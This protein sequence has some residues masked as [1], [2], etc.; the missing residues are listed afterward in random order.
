MGFQDTRAARATLYHRADNLFRNKTEVS[1]VI[2]AQA[3]LL[4]SNWTP[5]TAL[6]SELET[7]LPG[8]TYWL[9]QAVMYAR[10]AE[11]HQY[12]KLVEPADAKRAN[13]LK[14]LWW[15]CIIRDRVV[16]LCVR[17]G[18][19]IGRREFDFERNTPLGVSDLEDEAETS[20]V[21]NSGTKRA[22]LEILEHILELCV[23]LTDILA[24]VFPLDD[25]HGQATR[26]RRPDEHMKAEECRRELRRWYNQA[27]LKFP[28]AG[29][30]RHF[31]QQRPR[32]AGTEKE[33]RHGSV[34]LYMNL[35]Y[36]YYQ[37][38]LRGPLRTQH[39]LTVF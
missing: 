29:A 5:S 1:P 22:L 34:T 32:T 3:A 19:L 12:A 4:L 20:K 14:R 35:M 38:V 9:T 25:P 24:L 7:S 8:N 23:I 31:S 13:T 18:I 16:G 39:A 30:G 37:C 11:A 36:I 6:S 21:Y 33:F 17:R 10:N 2:L 28:E 26:E 15:C 27:T